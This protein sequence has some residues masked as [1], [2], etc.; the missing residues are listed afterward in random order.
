LVAG[1]L[2][3]AAG[4]DVSVS[5][6]SD[7]EKGRAAVRVTFWRAFDLALTMGIGKL[8]GTVV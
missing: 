2:S 5:S 1:A 8:F 7:T 6:Q 3:M 4:E